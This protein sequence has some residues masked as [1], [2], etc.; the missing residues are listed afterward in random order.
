VAER[1]RQGLL[2]FLETQ[3]DVVF[4]N[5]NEVCTLFETDNILEALSRLRTMVKLAAVTRGADGSVILRGTETL[6]VAAYPVDKVIDTTGAGDQYA[7]GFLFGLGTDRPL[8][9]CGQLG[10]LA[11]AEVIS[12]YGP[13]PQVRLA[14]LAVQKGL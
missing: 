2:A 11:A 4:A 5:Q 14:D 9:V 7:A 8:K 3:V 6:E 12:H 1:H 13:R 10:S